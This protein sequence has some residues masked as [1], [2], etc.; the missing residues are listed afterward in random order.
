[1]TP[2]L[3]ELGEDEP[4]WGL[5]VNDQFSIRGMEGQGVWN[6][7][8]KWLGSNQI[9]HFLWLAAAGK[10]LTNEERRR[11]HISNNGNCRRRGAKVEDVEHIL[12]DCQVA[13]EVWTSIIPQQEVVALLNQQWDSWFNTFLS[14]P[15]NQ[16]VFGITCWY[17][18]RSRNELVFQ[19]KKE[20]AP[21][22]RARINFWRASIISS[23]QSA[24]AL[25]NPISARRHISEIAWKPAIEG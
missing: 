13:I 20:D 17:L 2:P 4:V 24:M 9:R 16:L 12:R 11:R 22:I 8:W 3:G 25:R 15:T 6:S 5:E 19:G 18:W 14:H 1:M 21:T 10:L 23:W 7:V